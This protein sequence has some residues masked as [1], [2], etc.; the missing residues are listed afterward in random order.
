MK[1]TILGLSL[2]SAL[3]A[4]QPVAVGVG[5]AVQNEA[6][7]SRPVIPELVGYTYVPVA[8][9][10]FARAGGRAWLR[11]IEQP[12]MSTEAR[13]EER[14]L[15]AAAEAA[16][17]R[18]GPVVPTLAFGAGMIHRSISLTG[19]DLDISGAHIAN[20]ENLPVFYGQLSLGLPISDKWLIEPYVR[21]QVAVS[22]DRTHWRG[23][24]ELTYCWS[25]RAGLR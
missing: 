20:T 4:A 15:G 2:V 1:S 22:D 9:R 19:Q 13:V 18:D 12:R 10:W 11:G 25:C 24:I 5:V 7:G 23:G 16:I 8:Q 6:D 21:Y 14:D 17:V 3:A